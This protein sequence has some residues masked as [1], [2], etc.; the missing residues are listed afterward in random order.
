MGK[1]EGL[2]KL[3]NE[4]LSLLD[5]KLNEVSPRELV[6]DRSGSPLLL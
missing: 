2:L 6:N 1:I 5:K 4:N 3:I